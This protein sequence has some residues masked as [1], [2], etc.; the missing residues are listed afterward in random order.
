MTFGELRKVIDIEQVAFVEF[1]DYNKYHDKDVIKRGYYDN[2][3]VTK[4]HPIMQVNEEQYN[5]DDTDRVDINCKLM[6]W[7]THPKKEN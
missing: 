5:A 1:S 3:I 2:Y 6:V 4:V 7:L